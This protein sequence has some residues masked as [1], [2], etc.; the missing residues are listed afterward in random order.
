MIVTVTLN[1][2][3]DRT[4]RVPN[5][6]LGRRNRANASLA[7]PGGKGVNVARALR[8]LG[9]PVIATGLAGGRT[10][11]QIIEQLTDEGLLNDFVRIRDESRASMAL[12]DPT[13]G[14]QTEVNEYGP[15]VQAEELEILLSK[16]RYLSQGAEIFVLAGSMPRNVPSAFYATLLA[17]LRRQDVV[18]VLDA[19]GQVVRDSLPGEPALVSPNMFEA[20]E[21][22]GYEFADEADMAGGAEAITGM[23]AGGVLIHHED[24]CIARLRTPGGK[25]WTTYRAR[26]PRREDVVST[27]GSGDAFLAG[28]LAGRYTGE[29]HEASLARAVACGAA[30]TQSFGAGTF[31][32]ADVDALV[33]QVEVGSI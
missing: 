11:T 7:L 22:V 26:L 32:L 1:A 31:T 27:V 21:I 16:V 14:Q 24:G 9:Q 4:L 2:A 5:L 12:I 8:T 6:Q 20:E 19:A 25:G 13:N 15:E 18:T 10:G 17:E 30:S 29:A 28:F 23:G 3:L 33:R